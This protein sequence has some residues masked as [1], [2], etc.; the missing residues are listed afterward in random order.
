[1]HLLFLVN[2]KFIESRS[3]TALYY[4]IFY[5]SNSQ[6]HIHVYLLFFCLFFYYFLVVRLYSICSI[7]SSPISFLR[8]YQSILIQIFKYGVYYPIFITDLCTQLSIFT[9]ISSLLHLDLLKAFDNPIHRSNMAQHWERV[10]FFS[11][12][13]SPSSLFY[14]FTLYSKS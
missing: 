11:H 3:Y 5:Q 9:C 10:E 8:Q 7:C 13:I 4:V 12:L 6:F 2:F 1:M 14:L